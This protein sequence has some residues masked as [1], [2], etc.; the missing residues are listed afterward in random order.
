MTSEYV[1]DRVMELFGDNK[2]LCAET[3]VQVVAEPGGKECAD[4]VRA[5]TGFC[6]GVS[7][8][9]GHCGAVTGAIMG[10]GLYAGRA[11]PGEDHEAPYA[12]VQEFLDRFYNR[13]GGINCY[14]L[15]ECDFTVPEDK[16]RYRE[17]NLRLECYRMAV[18]AAETALSIL[19]EQG[20]LAEEADHVR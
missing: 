14:D 5:A 16:A 9:R 20:Y 3:V 11:E 6:S 2:F 7:R 15:I 1:R 13:Y 4:V 19:R 8:T 12:M 10:I 17:E 18:F